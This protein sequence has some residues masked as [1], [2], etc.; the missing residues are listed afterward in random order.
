MIYAKFNILIMIAITVG[1]LIDDKVS[2]DTSIILAAFTVT[3]LTIM[4]LFQELIDM[5]TDQSDI[6]N[7]KWK[8]SNKE[9]EKFKDNLDETCGSL[10]KDGELRY[11]VEK[12][13]N[14]ELAKEKGKKYGP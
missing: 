2:N 9:L 6:G 12:Q 1:S 11:F 10:I 14:E 13:V 5:Q 3:L 8:L 4:T 7:S